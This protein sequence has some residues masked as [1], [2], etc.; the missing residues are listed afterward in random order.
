MKPKANQINRTCIT[1]KSHDRDIA[2][3]CTNYWWEIPADRK[4]FHVKAALN[5]K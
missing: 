2:L 4:E 3:H 5:I 1:H